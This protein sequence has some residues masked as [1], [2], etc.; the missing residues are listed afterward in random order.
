MKLP[1]GS[2]VQ[3]A[4]ECPSSFALPQVREE[5][6]HAAKRGTTVHDFLK[7]VLSG[8]MTR[9][10]A[11]ALV[12]ED[13]PG[14]QAC[15]SADL[16]QLPHGAGRHEMAVAWDPE[17]D[18]ARILGHN[19]GR[20]YEEHGADRTREI[21]MSIDL[22]GD[23]IDRRVFVFD[24]KT[25]RPAY[26]AK[27]S[28]QLRTGA[29]IWSK[30]RGADEA[31]TGHI[32]INDDV[33]W[34][35]WEVDQ[36]ALADYESR[37]RALARKLREMPRRSDLETADVAEGSH[38]V[39]CPA[40]SRCPAKVGLVREMTRAMDT[41]GSE[42]SALVSPENAAWAWRM[43]DSYD[44]VAKRIR[45]QIEKMAEANPID[46]GDGYELRLADGEERD[47]VTDPAGALHALEREFGRDAA[48]AAAGTSKKA[49]TDAAR[50]H[51]GSDAVP[52]FLGKLR[53]EGILVKR[54]G[55]TKVREA[56]R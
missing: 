21:V 17:T 32:V 56:K 39:F 37:L 7:R 9:D 22:C 10:A 6:S 20:A 53:D 16:S 24:F 15:E 41:G 51:G 31:L 49:L 1:S 30:I 27:D 55:E 54:A 45:S 47:A 50:K 3:R 28:W 18:E 25:G 36:I 23:L 42:L 44:A 26:S 35:L 40:W 29:V 38:C 12:P 48:L 43:L 46:L 13:D 34:D 11:L 19:I 5:S 52:R 4:V 8:E 33:R 2:A 14:R